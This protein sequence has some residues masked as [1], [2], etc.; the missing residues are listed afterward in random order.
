MSY[1]R[2]RFSA[3]RDRVDMR[4]AERHG[5][6]FPTDA[7]SFFFVRHFP[8]IHRILNPESRISLGWGVA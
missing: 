8:D 4:E 1:F 2:H 6:T 5:G 7:T 3:G